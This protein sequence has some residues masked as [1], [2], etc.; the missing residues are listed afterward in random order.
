MALS[1][2]LKAAILTL[3]RE[4]K[5][6]LLL[7]LIGK[8]SDLQEQLEFQLIEGGSTLDER[9]RALLTRIDR[10]YRIEPE[11]SGYLMMDLRTIH[12]EITHHVKITKDKYG[13]VE[14]VLY[15]LQGVFE[16]QLRYIERYTSKTDT[17][18]QYVAK[19]TESLLKKY[20]ALHPDLQFEFIESLNLLLD[21]V[22][23]Y[24]PAHYARQLGLAKRV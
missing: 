24:A 7:R 3:P 21:R 23:R 13:E 16:H 4:E 8:H 11:S 10:L 2:E 22:H 5:D 9:R 15:L 20:A 19:R 1:K 18:A 14:L 12:G 6:K 17:L